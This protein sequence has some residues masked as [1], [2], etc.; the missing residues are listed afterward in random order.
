MSFAKRSV[1]LLFDGHLTVI[2]A[3][4]SVCL[5]IVLWVSHFESYAHCCDFRHYAAFLQCAAFVMRVENYRCSED[6]IEEMAQDYYWFFMRGMPSSGRPTST[7]DPYRTPLLSDLSS[8]MSS[9][10]DMSERSSDMYRSSGMP[11]RSFDMSSSSYVSERPSAIYSSSDHRMDSSYL[12]GSSSGDY[13]HSSR[14]P[15]DDHSS[16]SDVPGGDYRNSLPSI[17]RGGLYLISQVNV[18]V[19]CFVL[20]FCEWLYL[21]SQVNVLVYCFVLQFSEFVRVVFCWCTSDNNS[22]LSV[23]Q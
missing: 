16:S 17:C 18:L 19:Y 14:P 20:Q 2:Q 9:R 15:H 3:F 5:H 23:Q 4:L 12:Y 10:S 22:C 11:D 1:D 13:F 7:M 21:I 8:D 6:Q